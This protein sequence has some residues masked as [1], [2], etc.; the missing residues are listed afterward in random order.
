M[1][2]PR[3]EGRQG[4]RLTKEERKDLLAQLERQSSRSETAERILQRGEQALSGGHLDQAR[5]VLQ[6]LETRA[7]RIPGLDSFKQSLDAA[8]REEQRQAN[9]HTTEEMLS[10]YIQQRKKP[11]AEMALATL[12]ELAPTHPRRADYQRWVAD[13]D[14]E[15]AL[16]RR[17][18]EHFEAGQAAL[19]RGDLAAAKKHLE[20]LHKADP[21]SSVAER[22]ATEIANAAQGQA[23][24][25]GIEEAKRQLDELLAADRL[26]EAEQQME[27]LSR[28]DIPKVTIDFLRQRLEEGRQ[29]LRDQADAEKLMPLFES[30]LENRDWPRAR[31]AAQRF[32]RRFP[33]SPR[34]S[35]LF[36]RIN[37]L[38]AAERRQQSLQA[39]LS[40]VE[41]FITEGNRHD[42]ELAFKLLSS[43]DLDA[44]RLA[45][46]E[47]RVRKI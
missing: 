35:E 6:Q 15:M 12:L 10:R 5:R 47:A 37:E 24:S 43:L 17:I 46:L 26:D 13:L 8:Q 42:A 44:A 38:E 18:D 41:R 2:E 22:L 16:Q 33:T 20:A 27:R 9:L 31:E 40:A 4:I 32:G 39:G 23:L 19:Q 29:R 11:L 3:P 45:E 25:A 7:P 1:A 14:Q 30:S 28:M 21:H 34:T 36:S